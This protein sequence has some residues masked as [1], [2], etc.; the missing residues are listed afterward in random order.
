[1]AVALSLPSSAATRTVTLTNNGPSP[2][3]ITLN[4]GDRVTFV[5][6]DNGSHTVTDNAGPWSFRAS[7]APGRS[8]STP[9]FSAAGHY[10]YNDAFF[11]AVVQQNVD[12]AIEVRAAAPSPTPKPTVKPTVKPTGRPTP[13]RTPSPSASAGR[14][15]SPT[16]RASDEPSP[17]PSVTNTQRLGTVPVLTLPPTPGPTPAVAPPVV[18]PVVSPTAVTAY[19]PVSEIAQRSA[20][21]YGLPVLLALLAAAGVLSLMVRFL[22]AVPAG[23]GTEPAG[24]TAAVRRTEGEGVVDSDE[25]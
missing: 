10:G 23:S 20:H 7:I 6:A 2:A 13:T 12:G 14:T 5:N 3:S 19:G 25:G 4:A 22:L 18:P 16:P 21:R 1:A 11:V 9:A 17:S 24:E 15:P 8:A